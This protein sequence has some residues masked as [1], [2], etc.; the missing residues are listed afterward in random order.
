[1]G[2]LIVLIIIVFIVVV[3]F[4]VLAVGGLLFGGEDP[5]ERELA[6]MDY[7]DEVRDRLD[8]I[9]SRLDDHDDY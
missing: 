5:Y 2:F 8:R 4:I 1:M 7:E 3:V 9:E 6:R